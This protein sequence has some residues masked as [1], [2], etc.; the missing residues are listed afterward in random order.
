MI[1]FTIIVFV[2][3]DNAKASSDSV[4]TN[5][6]RRDFNWGD[7]F[8]FDFDDTEQ[9]E[10]VSIIAPDEK[11]YTPPAYTPPRYLE[12]IK[13]INTQ[14]SWGKPVF[15]GYKDLCNKDVIIK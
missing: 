8:D 4:E 12:I 14:K 1:F 9:S 7:G 15:Q 3:L 10:E 2:S 5:R 13:L 11:K 6:N